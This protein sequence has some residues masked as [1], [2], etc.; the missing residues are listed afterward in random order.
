[1]RSCTSRKFFKGDD[2]EP[3]Q[4]V[5]DHASVEF[6]NGHYAVVRSSRFDFAEHASM[7]AWARSTTGGQ[8]L[9]RQRP[10]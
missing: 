4:S 2:M 9:E 6:L 7:A 1:M 8:V 3:Y 10:G 5:V